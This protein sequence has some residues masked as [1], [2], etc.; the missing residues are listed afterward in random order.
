[1]SP[2]QNG[3]IQ[4]ETYEYPGWLRD[5]RKSVR[6][7]ADAHGL[8]DEYANVVIDMLGIIIG[9]EA[10]GAKTKGEI[11]AAVTR[12][13]TIRAPDLDTYVETEWDKRYPSPRQNCENQKETP[14]K[15]KT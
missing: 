11:T 3:E 5:R 7:V 9:E 8:S 6:L 15:T 13:L 4:K 12:A 1:M 14:C 10:S 2:R